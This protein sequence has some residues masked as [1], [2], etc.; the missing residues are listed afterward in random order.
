MLPGNVYN[1]GYDITVGTREDA[2]QVA[3][4]EKAEIRIAMEALF[5]ERA[6]QHG[7]QH[8]R[9][10]GPAISTAAPSRKAGST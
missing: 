5:R 4:T 10:A 8:H 2:P 7:V 6:E 3:S 9:A 1:F